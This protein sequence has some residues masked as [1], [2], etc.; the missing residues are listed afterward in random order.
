MDK[1]RNGES[2]KYVITYSQMLTIE[3][4]WWA[5]V[6]LLWNSTWLSID[7]FYNKILGKNMS[8]ESHWINYWFLGRF[9]YQNPLCHFSFCFAISSWV[10]IFNK[11]EQYSEWHQMW[12][13]NALSLRTSLVSQSGTFFL[14]RSKWGKKKGDQQGQLGVKAQVS[15][16]FVET[17]PVPQSLVNAWLYGLKEFVFLKPLALVFIAPTCVSFP[18]AFPV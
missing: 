10:I 11:R 4:S 9:H 12:N 1:G 7:K 5:H 8:G 13:V 3:S 2:D 18:Q 15:E 16:S 6:C 14:L 17:L